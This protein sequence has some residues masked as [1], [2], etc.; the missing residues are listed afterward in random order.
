MRKGAKLVGPWRS[1]HT[2]VWLIGLAILFWK[3]WWWPGI[4]VLVGISAIV[5]AV[6]QLAVPEAVAPESKHE[7]KAPMPSPAVTAATAPEPQHRADQLPSTCPGCG[8]PRDKFVKIE[9]E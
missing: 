3:G 2:A 5:E 6:I 4:L 1:I 9:E 7:K 8:A